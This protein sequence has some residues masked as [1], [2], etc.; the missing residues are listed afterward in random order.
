MENDD[1]AAESVF[2]TNFR[3]D[4]QRLNSLPPAVLVSS[5]LLSELQES[6]LLVGVRSPSKQ[7]N[8]PSNWVHAH[9]EFEGIVVGCEPTLGSVGQPHWKV[10]EAP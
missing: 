3:V 6:G 2:V 9:L 7:E 4:L 8:R 5:R 10:Y 1:Q